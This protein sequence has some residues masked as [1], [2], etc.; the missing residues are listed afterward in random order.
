MT[1]ISDTSPLSALAEIG[2]LSL[3]RQLFGMVILPAAVLQECI[4]EGAPAALR[5]WAFTLPDWVI[6]DA[7]S[8]RIPS[9]DFGLDPGETAVIALA[10]EAPG[11]VLLLM[12][13][14]AGVAVAR[15][16]GLA[17]T[18]TLGL[19]V[20]GQQLGLIDFETA[21]AGLRHTRFR[22]TEALIA[23]AR[24]LLA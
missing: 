3:L 2:E 4:Q 22:F 5:Q 12:D 19:L 16:L 15:S 20:R 17:F 11:P 1:V 23:H 10:L 9:A 18:G 21:V 6:S 7:S 24:R 13:E 8:V 14:R